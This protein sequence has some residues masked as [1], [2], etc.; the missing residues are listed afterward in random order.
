[1]DAISSLETCTIHTTSKLIKISLTSNFQLQCTILWTVCGRD[2]CLE[3]YE[4]RDQS[5]VEITQGSSGISPYFS[6]LR[7]TIM[8]YESISYHL[9]HIIWLTGF[10]GRSSSMHPVVHLRPWLRSLCPSAVQIY[11]RDEKKIKSISDCKLIF[12]VYPNVMTR[13]AKMSHS[14]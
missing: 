1:M 4:T 7:I 5:R 10:H 6:T 12:E 14:S 8:R 2:N 3:S 13:L 11:P 9:I